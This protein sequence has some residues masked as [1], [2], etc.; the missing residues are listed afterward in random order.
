MNEKGIIKEHLNIKDIV[1]DLLKEDE[2]C[3]NSDK[4]LILEVFKK[5]DVKV[6]FDYKRVCID[7]TFEEFFALPS[8]ES[9][10]RC[11]AEIQN[12]DCMF[13][14]TDPK[15]LIKRKFKEEVIRKYYGEC[16]I[17]RDWKDSYYNII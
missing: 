2:R 6:I 16:K 1:F 10:R 12:N 4:I 17:Y 3:R 11:R 5:C 14:P 9:I 13:L 15:V 8:T 7:A